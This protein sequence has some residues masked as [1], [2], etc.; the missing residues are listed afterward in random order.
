M[1]PLLKL[2]FIAAFFFIFFV[3]VVMLKPMSFHAKRRFSTAML[4]FSYLSY[5]AILLIFVYVFMFY[6]G[7]TF[8]NITHPE[9][10]IN[11]T[12]F[13]MMMVSFFIPNLGIF[14]RRRVKMRSAYNSTMST[15][16]IGFM[17]YLWFLIE[18]SSKS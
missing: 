10:S 13:S 18:L 17:V 16:N 2:L 9:N 6:G 15:L 8:F 12:H 7:D 4:K 3:A 5:L 11:T 14:I 1:S